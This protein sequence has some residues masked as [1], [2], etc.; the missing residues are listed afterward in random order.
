MKHHHVRLNRAIL[1]IVLGMGAAAL[2]AWAAEPAESAKPTAVVQQAGAVNINTASADELADALVGVGPAKA[3][4][5]VAHREANG[6]FTDKAQ[7][8]QVQG[9][10]PAILEQ[11]LDRIEL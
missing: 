10:G 2:P 4:A 9:I 6:A 3:A 1:A 11:N 5:I 8:Q 7:L